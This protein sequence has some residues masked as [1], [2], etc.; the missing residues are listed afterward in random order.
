VEEAEA[1]QKA[2]IQRFKKQAAMQREE[3][4]KKALE[5]PSAKYYYDLKKCMLVKLF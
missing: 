4:E 2:I 3:N 1:R 5:K